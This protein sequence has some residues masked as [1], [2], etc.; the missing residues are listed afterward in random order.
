MEE[1][2]RGRKSS[3][4]YSKSREYNNE[5]YLGNGSAE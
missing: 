3:S 5:L 2:S 1:R 4:D